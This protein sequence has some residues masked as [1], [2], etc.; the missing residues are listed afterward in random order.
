MPLSTT[1]LDVRRGTSGVVLPETVLS[2]VLQNVQENSF[3][4]QASQ[5]LTIPGTGVKMNVIT[6]DPE[7][8]WVDETN[9]KA[10]STPTF[11]NK[12]MTPYKM[13]VIVPFSNEFRRDANTL[14][15]AVVERVPLALAKKYD[16][17][18]FFGEAP[19]A[20]FDTLASVD[21]VDIQADTYDT[22][23]SAVTDIT[24]N[25]GTPNAFVFAPQA[26]N[27]LLGT[28]DAQERPLFIQNV[29]TTG[30]VGQ[31]LGIPAY[32]RHAAY[33]AG[34]S[35]AN[36]MGFLGDW[37]NAY[38]GMVQNVTVEFS[39]Q[40]TINDGTNTINLWQRNMFA[41]RCEMEVGFIVKDAN[42]YVRLTDT[43][44]AG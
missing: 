27:I 6:G 7:P 31:I 13:A 39:D 15:S 1:N 32:Y 20:N 25:Y 41:L 14:Y 21:A 42:H 16:Q 29:N 26:S 34:S 22:L 37:S 17:T 28:K 23:V 19:G 33:K 38:V 12:V 5:N 11:S 24:V 9:E 10:V 35:A 40:A 18:V 44:S 2:T 36:T 3:I 30:S 8:A 4:M 43:Y